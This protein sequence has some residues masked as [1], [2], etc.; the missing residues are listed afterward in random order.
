VD[1]QD[2]VRKVLLANGCCAG[3]VLVLTA[4]VRDLHRAHPA[5][6]VLGVETCF[7]DIWWNNPYVASLDPGDPEVTRIDCGH[8]PLLDRCG[9]QPRHYVESVH[10]L[11]RGRLGVE[12]PLTRFAPDLHLSEEERA[13]VPHGL[14]APYWVIVGGGKRDLTIKWW[15][16]AFYQEVVDHFA[17]QVNFVQVGGGGD[18]HPPL[19]GVVMN[20]VGRT[21]VREL[22]R[23][24]YH[25]DGVVCPVTCVMHI[26][27]AF[28]KPCV[29][30]AGGRE[31]PHWEMYPMH[32]FL[33]TVGQ[34][35]CCARSGC[36]KA[37]VVPLEDGDEDRDHNL[38]L[39]P[40]ARNGQAVARCMAMIEPMDVCR[41]LD[42]YRSGLLMP[43]LDG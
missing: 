17:G 31:P 41:A 4:A 11:L 42:R 2:T 1:A 24:V 40:A 15:P 28:D 14:Q 26:A 34:L 22:M 7:P 9:D 35:P 36:W 3:D 39:C 13:G 30:V 6:Y 16:T 33:H 21:T 5:R 18:Y 20:L 32:Q 43:V 10:D 23:L 27:A 37:R 8:P 19:R 12:I 38:C 25:A 29:V